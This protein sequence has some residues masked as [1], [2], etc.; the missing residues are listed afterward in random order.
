M[1][2]FLIFDQQIGELLLR[3]VPPTLPA[4]HDA[5]AKP[6]GIDFLTHSFFTA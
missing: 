4:D 5:G 1:A 3:G 2:N 6:D